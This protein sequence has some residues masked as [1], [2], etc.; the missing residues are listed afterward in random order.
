[1]IQ[2]FAATLV[3]LLALAPAAHAVPADRLI[4]KI[5]DADGLPV[6]GANVVTIEG[7]NSYMRKGIIWS[8]SNGV[9]VTEVGRDAYL[10]LRVTAPGFQ[11]WQLDL[12]PGAPERKGKVI[13]VRLE[14]RRGKGPLIPVSL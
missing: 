3:L 4:V 10:G 8:D 9:A 11:V 6:A 12:A 7:A 14:K 1:V 13:E 5:K 2:R